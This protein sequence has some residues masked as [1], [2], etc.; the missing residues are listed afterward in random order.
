MEFKVFMQAVENGIDQIKSEA[1]LREWLKNYAR[2]IPENDREGFLKYFEKKEYHTHE[3][4]LE[5][6]IDWCGIVGDGEL[7]LSCHGYEEY[8]DSY[9]DRDWVTEYDDPYGMGQKLERFY[10]IAEQCV[11]DRDYQTAI[12]IYDALGTLEIPAY[13][14]DSG[15]GYDL[16]IVELN[17]EKLTNLDLKRIASLTLYSQYQISEPEKRSEEIYKYFYESIYQKIKIED[18]MS[19]GTEPLE[20]IDEFMDSWIIYL[21]KQDHKFTARLLKEAVMYKDGQDGLLHEAKRCAVTHPGLFIEVLESFYAAEAWE[22]LAREGQEALLLMDCDMQIRG[23]AARL[24]AA[25]ARGIGDK[26]GEKESYF[27][28][29][30]SEMSTE[31]YLRLI[32]CDEIT[33]ED[34]ESAE[35]L[36]QKHGKNRAGKLKN[37]GAYYEENDKMQ[38]RMTGPNYLELRFLSGEYKEI[39][40]ECK[41]QQEDLGWSGNFINE[42]VPMLLMLLCRGGFNGRAMKAIVSELER[43]FG[44]SQKY[45]EPAFENLICIWK[46]Q[47]ELDDILASEILSYLQ[48]TIDGRVA[49]IVSGG[50]RNS[51][52]KAARLGAALGEAE[53]SM[54]ILRAKERRIHKYF[55]QFPRHRAFKEEMKAYN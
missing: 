32:T 1:G 10:E 20:G 48:K 36:L 22:R 31:N 54:G 15:D 51:Y 41:K 28:A 35:Q 11:Y 14:E 50:H 30:Y 13:D 44:Y 6:I 45:G 5:G 18:M 42:G 19:A 9:W 27:K 2:T 17:S 29:F 52:Y 40:S 43:E 37:S 4:E 38:Y 3:Q 26:A 16:S 12:S 47:V 46:K 34:R 23:K 55:E 39:L 25:G 7:V 24:A 33:K 21:R 49:A 53:E 8:G